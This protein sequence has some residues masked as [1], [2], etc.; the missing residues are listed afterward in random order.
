M[1][2]YW[3]PGDKINTKGLVIWISD[4]SKKKSGGGGPVWEDWDW[5][6]REE[7]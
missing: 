1:S 5:R 7:P 2:G 3:F 6:R 4:N